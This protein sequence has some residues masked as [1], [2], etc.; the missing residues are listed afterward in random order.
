MLV[1]EKIT[2]SYKGKKALQEVA[3]ELPWGIY[4]LLG[5]NGAGKSTLMNISQG[6]WLR[7]RGGFSGTGRTSAVWGS[8]FGA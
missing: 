1:L 4:G 6:T 2:K 7:M 5:P 8:V 3:L